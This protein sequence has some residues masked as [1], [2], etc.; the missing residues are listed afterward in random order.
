MISTALADALRASAQADFQL[1]RTVLDHRDERVAEIERDPSTTTMYRHMAVN[2]VALEIAQALRISEQQVWRVA[3]QARRL[4]DHLPTVWSAFASGA[5]TQQK[6]STLAVVVDRLDHPESRAALDSAAVAYAETH[7]P[8]ELRR[9]ADQL[10]DRLEPTPLDEAETA[11]DDRRV[12][13]DHARNGMSYLLGTIP[14]VAAVAIRRR[15]RAGAKALPDDDRTLEQKM[16]DLFMAWLTITEGTD[17]DIKAD[18]A[19]IV[20]AEALAGVSNAPALVDPES[21]DPAP[22]P[23]SWVLDLAQTGNTLWTQLLTDHHGRLLDTT[24]LGYQPP[25]ALRRA[26]RW[27]DLRCSISGCSRP[28]EESDLDHEKPFDTGGRTSGTNLNH[29]C[30]RHHGMKGHHVLPT[31]AYRQVEPIMV[32]LPT[33]PIT[34]EYVA[35]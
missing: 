17:C 25:A 5:I 7:T 31:H 9:W 20:E 19:V 18:V 32:R 35:A 23:A 33:P 24:Y 16:A 14:T 6:A 10:A 15:L 4:R 30:R 22:I 13:V 27:R 12:D 34:I 26:L 29:K 3:E 11:R 8:S 2:A 28:A 1:W 21:T